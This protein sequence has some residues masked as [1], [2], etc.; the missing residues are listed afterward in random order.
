MNVS[1]R[2]IQIQKVEVLEP[3]RAFKLSTRMCVW[4][5]DDQMY[6]FPHLL[7]RLE[8]VSLWVSE[9]VKKYST[10]EEMRNAMRL[11]L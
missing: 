8:S 11:L 2:S 3:S 5:W 7:Y 6:F 10:H 9:S 4:G 1:S